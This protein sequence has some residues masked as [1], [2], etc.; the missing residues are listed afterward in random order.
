MQPS[1]HSAANGPVAEAAVTPEDQYV[2][3][4]AEMFDAWLEV[5]VDKIPIRW[6]GN[7]IQM[8]WGFRSE[9]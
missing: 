3:F 2:R 6:F 8:L 7:L 4:L 5:G 9:V 1:C